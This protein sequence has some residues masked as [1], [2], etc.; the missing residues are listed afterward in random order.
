MKGYITMINPLQEF[1]VING[2]K[3]EK[4]E[5]P[6][7]MAYIRKQEVLDVFPTADGYSCGTIFRELHKPFL[8]GQVK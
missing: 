4:A 3:P 2:V 1:I 7:A 5:V 8:G 6:L